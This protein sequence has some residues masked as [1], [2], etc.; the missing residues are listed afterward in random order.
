[1]ELPRFRGCI[2]LFPEH[3]FRN[4]CNRAEDSA[5]SEQE[6]AASSVLDDGERFF[7]GGLH[8]DVPFCVYRCSVPFSLAASGFG[9]KALADERANCPAILTPSES[10]STEKRRRSC[11]KDSILPEREW[12]TP[13]AIR[14]P[15]TRMGGSAACRSQRGRGD[16]HAGTQRWRG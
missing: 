14:I 8:G 11:L 2:S 9:W 12:R 3:Q 13:R 4:C 10:V 6:E 15:K 16:R 7:F 5:G 1:M